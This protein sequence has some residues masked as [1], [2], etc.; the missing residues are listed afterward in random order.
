M[1]GEQGHEM[2]KDHGICFPTGL[3]ALGQDS[4]LLW[5]S[6]YKTESHLPNRQGFN[7][8]GNYKSPSL[9]SYLQKVLKYHF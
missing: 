9:G 3:D 4:K 7:Q 5:A 1:L 8:V 2:T 6:V